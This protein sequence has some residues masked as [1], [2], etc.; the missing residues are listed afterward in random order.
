MHLEIH[1]QNSNY[2]QNQ[3]GL[4]SKR[5]TSSKLSQ[6]QSPIIPICLKQ[7]SN[8]ENEVPQ[9]FDGE[10]SIYKSFIDE[11]Y[12]VRSNFPNSPSV[13]FQKKKIFD[14]IQIPSQKTSQIKTN[15]ILNEKSQ[16]NNQEIYHTYQQLSQRDA[17]LI[18]QHPYFENQIKSLQIDSQQQ[19]KLECLKDSNKENQI[20]FK[21]KQILITLKRISLIK[22]ILN[23]ELTFQNIG[24]IPISVLD[25]L[26]SN[27]QTLRLSKENDCIKSLTPGYGQISTITIEIVN[28]PF[29]IV[30]VSLEYNNQ[31]FKT[32]LPITILNFIQDYQTTQSRCVNNH[33]HYNKLIINKKNWN[34]ESRI[35]IGNI[36]NS[37]VEIR[38]ENQN[39]QLVLYCQSDL[40]QLNWQILNTLYVLFDL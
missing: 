20:V 13:K 16:T 29:T 1:P 8:R 6:H 40:E 36:L 9:E 39:N 3:A 21:N 28:V 24:N 11:Y 30:N 38:V 15:Q 10:K 23:C 26:Y 34:I 14:D 37:E 31:F 22:N 5:E 35:I 17:T 27:D 2:R 18:Q 12:S 4:Q 19:F 33:N 32:Y 7:S 25:V